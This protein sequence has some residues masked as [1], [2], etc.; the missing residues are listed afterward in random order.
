MLTARDHARVGVG[1]HRVGQDEEERSD[2]GEFHG[3]IG[4]GIVDRF[5]SKA[6]SARYPPRHEKLIVENPAREIYQAG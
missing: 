1:E 3:R 2:Q 4:S 6:K 5:D